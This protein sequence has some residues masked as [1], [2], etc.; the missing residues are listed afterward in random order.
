MTRSPMLA[1][2]LLG[3]L[4]A[5]AAAHVTIDPP[6][7]VAGSYLRAAFRVPHGCGSA[8]TQ[9]VVITLPEGVLMARPMPK[10]GWTL[11]V[12]EAPLATPIDNGHGGQVTKRVAEIAWEGGNL[13]DAWYDEFVV[14]LRLPA[15]ANETLWMPAVQHC[16]GGATAAW[17][18]IPEAGRRV[19]DYRYPAPA[20]RLLPPRTPREGGN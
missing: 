8:A 10:P 11:R 12:T 19:S 16:E 1:A 3:L 15:T 4:A 13:P 18:Q 7:A 2:A 17:T 20:L 6:Q 9:R 14:M 5:P